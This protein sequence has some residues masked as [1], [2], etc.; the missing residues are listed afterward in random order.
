MAKVQFVTP[1]KA[2]PIEA[3][4]CGRGQIQSRAYFNEE[5][6]PL[7]LQLHQLTADAALD[8]TSL[9]S[10]T[11]VYVWTG[12]LVVE[13]V[14][15]G[16]RSSLIMER[17][18]S[19]EMSAVDGA[20]TLLFFTP[21]AQRRTEEQRRAEEQRR[22]GKNAP[23]LLLLPSE[24]VPRNPDL[25]GQGLAGGALHADASDTSCRLW[26]HENDFYV[27]D[28]PVAVHSHS[29]DE[30]IFVRDGELRAGGRRYGP[31]AA[32]AVAAHTK[33]GFQVGPSGLSFVN[34]RASAPT[35]TSHDGKHSMDEAEFWRSQTGRPQYMD[36]P[37]G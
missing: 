31:G 17:G 21:K 27:G 33:Y 20:A 16:E 28:S 1:D 24:R 9:A 5:S 26:L 4:P 12:A 2:A 30:I 25:G 19:T 32:L 6:D 11:L 35:Y 18:A 14:R 36:F 34:F 23:H 15:L 7:H 37:T 13:G 22:S 8:V 29:E 10:D 3:P